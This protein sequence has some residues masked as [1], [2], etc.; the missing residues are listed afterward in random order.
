MRK[1]NIIPIILIK[2]IQFQK[3]WTVL[4]SKIENNFLIFKYSKTVKKYIPAIISG[5]NNVI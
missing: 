4:V 1:N 3:C 5:R 2:I